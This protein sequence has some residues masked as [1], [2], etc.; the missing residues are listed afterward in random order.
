MGCPSLPTRHASGPE[1]AQTSAHLCCGL[2]LPG[3]GVHRGQAFIDGFFAS[4]ASQLI[5]VTPNHT[6]DELP[7]FRKELRIGAGCHSRQKARHGV[8]DKVSL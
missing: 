4:E 6:G 1:L 8:F 5:V 2:G 3:S 7:A